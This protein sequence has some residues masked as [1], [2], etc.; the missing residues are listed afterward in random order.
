MAHGVAALRVDERHGGE[1]VAGG[2]EARLPPGG[3][4]VVR[5]HDH[6]VVA[7]GDQPRP[8]VCNGDE[9]GARGE[10]RVKRL[11]RVRLRRPGRAGTGRATG[12][13]ARRDRDGA[14]HAAD[15]V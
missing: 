8:R 11:R 14:D 4:A 7:D 6:A 1:Q 5:Q 12:Q 13:R 10:G 15:A 9:R 3:A 2:D